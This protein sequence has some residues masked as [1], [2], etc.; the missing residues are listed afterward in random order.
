[1]VVQNAGELPPSARD[2]LRNESFEV[3]YVEGFAGA[4]KSVIEAKPDLIVIDIESW[5]KNVEELLCEFGNL[6][7][8]R[9][10]RKVVLAKSAKAEGSSHGTRSGCR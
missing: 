4:R 7:N 2:A 3:A 8:T 1:M 5:A 9:S 6:R 10:S